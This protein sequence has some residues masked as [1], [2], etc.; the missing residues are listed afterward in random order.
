M[1]PNPILRSSLNARRSVLVKLMNSSLRNDELRVALDELDKGLKR[2]DDDRYGT[3]DVCGK[4]IDNGELLANPLRTQCALHLAAEQQRNTRREHAIAEFLYRYRPVR[5]TRARNTL[6][7]V[8]E[9]APRASKEPISD[10]DNDIGRARNVQTDL[11]PAAYLRHGPWEISYDYI[12]SGVLSGDYCDLVPENSGEIFLLVGDSMGKGIAASLIGARLH[13]LFR[14]LL[15]P[16]VSISA[17]IERANR[18]LCDCLLASGHYAT[19]VCGRTT[20]TGS[21]EFVNAGHLPPLALHENGIE[22]TTASGLPLGLFAESSYSLASINLEPGD[23]LVCYTDGLTEARNLEENEY[24][25]ERL[26]EVALRNRHLSPRGLVRAC[27]EDVSAY[28]SRSNFAD[29]F[30]LLALRRTA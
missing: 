21:F 24:G 25:C 10:I 1:E 9:S 19:L 28:M 17:V 29:D 27:R 22:R 20:P 15:Q 7:S 14:T 13:V 2:M 4:Q 3:C 30:T 26:S 18:I 23:T 11:M 8:L 5:T 6:V 16:K 12:P